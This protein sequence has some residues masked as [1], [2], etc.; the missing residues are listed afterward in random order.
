[1]EELLESG[2]IKPEDDK[3]RW[4]LFLMLVYVPLGCAAVQLFAWSRFKLH[5]KHLDHVRRAR[6]N[7]RYEHAR[8]GSGS[9]TRRPNKLPE[10]LGAAWAQNKGFL[11]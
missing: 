4:A 1:M 11:L 10:D 5:G 6:K 7:L 2:A 3:V 8:V 9:P